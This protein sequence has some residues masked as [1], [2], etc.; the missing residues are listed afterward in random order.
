LAPVLATALADGI[1]KAGMEHSIRVLSTAGPTSGDQNFINH[2]H[3]KI[4]NYQ[5]I[6]NEIDVVP[7]AWITDDLIAA[8]AF[9]PTEYGFKGFPLSKNNRIVKKFMEWASDRANEKYARKASNQMSE[10]NFEIRTWNEE[11]LDKLPEADLASIVKKM[12]LTL[13]WNY[14]Y[15]KYLNEICKDVQDD[16]ITEFCAFLVYLGLQHVLAYVRDNGFNV[17]VAMKAMKDELSPFKKEH[18]QSS[19]LVAAYS[20]LY[21]LGPLLKKVANWAKNHPDTAN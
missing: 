21:I 4:A 11:K 1:T 17:E 6:Y 2:V 3:T 19:G 8:A 13:K 15:N 7:R 20:L 5:A 9:Y 16:E 18:G 10:H 14:F 12:A